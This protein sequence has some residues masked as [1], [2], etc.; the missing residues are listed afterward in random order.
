MSLKSIPQA[1][2]LLIILVL[3]L[4]LF[5]LFRNLDL[6]DRGIWVDAELLISKH[7]RESWTTSAAINPAAEPED[8][9]D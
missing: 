1:V 5:L 6:L 7:D 8:T 4:S 9:I 3:F 2:T